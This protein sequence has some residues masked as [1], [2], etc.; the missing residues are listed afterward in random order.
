MPHHPSTRGAA[1]AAVA[2]NPAPP[3]VFT[4]IFFK[5]PSK[6]ACQAPKTIKKLPTN[7]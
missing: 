5:F 2:E 1:F 6:I 4:I 3:F 7:T